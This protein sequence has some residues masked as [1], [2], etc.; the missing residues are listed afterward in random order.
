MKHDLRVTDSLQLPWTLDS[1][2]AVAADDPALETVHAHFAACPDLE[3][4]FASAI[5][6]ALD[7]VIDGPRTG[8]FRYS[9]LEKTEK[10]YIGTRIEI[11][12][13]VALGLDRVGRLDTL[14]DGI[15]VD[16]KWS[17]SEAWMIPTEAVDEIC[18][19]LGTQVAGGEI[20]DVGLVRCRSE[21]LNVGA[22]KDGKRTLNRLGRQSIRWLVR[23]GSLPPNF[24][25]TIPDDV[26]KA[27]LAE[28]SGQAR[29]RL[30]FNLLPPGTPV[31]RGAA[32]TLGQ[33]ADPMRR[34]RADRSDRLPGLKIFSGRYLASRDAV[35]HLGYGAMMKDSFVAVP[36]ARLAEL[37]AELRSRLELDD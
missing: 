32:A 3:R 18:L 7:E 6:Q 8:R 9:E 19:L 15:P 28:R 13:R 23:N 16:I 20:F 14:V 29:L 24:L 35:E 4:T 26:V 31:P 10:T 37:P 36:R 34:L 30:L 11:V 27:V 1:V 22:N 25:E 12:V 21:L 17:A 33:Q 2:A 5:R